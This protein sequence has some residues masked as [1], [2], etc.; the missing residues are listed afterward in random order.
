MGGR[1]AKQQNAGPLHLP[2]NNVGVMALDYKGKE[3]VAT[4][5]G[6]SRFLL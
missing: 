4:T 3:G 6:H 5:I 2:L 1:V